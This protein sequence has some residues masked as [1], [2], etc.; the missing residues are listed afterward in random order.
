MKREVMPKELQDK[1]PTSPNPAMDVV[2]FINFR[3]CS[4]V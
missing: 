4:K 3:E 1:S 2:V